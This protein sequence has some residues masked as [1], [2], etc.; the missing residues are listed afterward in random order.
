GDF[1][2]EVS[3]RVVGIFHVGWIDEWSRSFQWSLSW[4]VWIVHRETRGKAG[5]VVK[6]S[7]LIKVGRVIA[8]GRPEG[9]PGKHWICQVSSAHHVSCIVGQEWKLKVPLSFP[10]RTSLVRFGI[11]VVIS[12]GAASCRWSHVHVSSGVARRSA[13][14]LE[15]SSGVRIV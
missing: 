3:S 7:P 13:V 5:T 12:V 4:K 10:G 11:V 14:G 2:Q 6:R 9:N 15:E 1:F 8:L